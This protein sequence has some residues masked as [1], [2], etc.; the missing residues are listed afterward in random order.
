MKQIK[1]ELLR[2]VYKISLGENCIYAEKEGGQITL[3]TWDNHDK[4]W[5]ENS[6]PKTIEIVGK[7]IERA[8]K[9]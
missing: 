5:F 7:L 2:Q 9:I 3:K 4:F 6:T 8:G 1:T